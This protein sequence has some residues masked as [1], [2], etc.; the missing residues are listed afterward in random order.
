MSLSDTQGERVVGAFCETRCANGTGSEMGARVIF[1]LLL[2]N[3]NGAFSSLSSEMTCEM[4]ESGDFLLYRT[5]ASEPSVRMLEDKVIVSSDV[6]FEGI[7]WNEKNVKYVST[8]KKLDKKNVT[9]NCAYTV[10]FPSNDE[11][12]WDVGKKYKVSTE[13]LMSENGIYDSSSVLEGAV[14]V[15]NNKRVAF[16][17]NL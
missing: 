5:V 2:E 7:G 11:T 13:A 15:P 12:L 16:E 3:E 9:K 17:K 8:V 10:F 6:S 4:S 14:I 1:T